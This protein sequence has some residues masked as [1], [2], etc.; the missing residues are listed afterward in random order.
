VHHRKNGLLNRSSPIAA[1]VKAEKV[2]S[3]A[4]LVMAPFLL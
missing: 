2:N 4:R 1:M 3:I